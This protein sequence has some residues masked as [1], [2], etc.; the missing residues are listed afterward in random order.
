MGQDLTAIK[1]GDEGAIIACD[2]KMNSQMSNHCVKCGAKCKGGERY[3]VCSQGCGRHFHE[4][5]ISQKYRYDQYVSCAICDPSR[6]EEYC[7][8]CGDQIDA[9]GNILSC[10]DN[11]EAFV[12]KYCIPGG[13]KFYRCG[14]CT[15]AVQ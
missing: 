13:S 14:I 1:P 5:C 15:L 3:K 4:K 9:G 12:H 7:Q 10:A 2:I 11:C 8:V 6:R